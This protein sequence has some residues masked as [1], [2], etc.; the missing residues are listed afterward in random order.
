MSLLQ[1]VIASVTAALILA[2]L[3]ADAAAEVDP[4]CLG[5]LC[6]AATQCNATTKCHVPYAGAYFCGPFHISWA[7]WADAGK[8]VLQ[9]DNPERK[10]AFEDCATDL[11]CSAKIV[12]EYMNKFGKDCDGDGVVSCKDYVRIHKLGKAACDVPLPPDRFTAQFEKCV[13]RLNVF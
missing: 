3:S 6:E 1:R 10:G 13:T 11:Y 7:Y 12:R 4:N 9:H 8:P 5:C 2:V